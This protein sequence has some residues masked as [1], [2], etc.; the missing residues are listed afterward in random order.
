MCYFVSVRDT[1]PAAD[2]RYHELL[3]A[4][5]P[6]RRLEAAMKLTQAVR[7]L[8]LAGIQ[9]LFPEASDEELRVRLTVRLYGRTVAERLFVSVPAD[10]R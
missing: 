3:R 10:A 9:E 7:Q 5:P 6:E 2:A 8:A 1:S 4:M